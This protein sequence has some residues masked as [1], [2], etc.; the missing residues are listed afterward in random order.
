MDWEEARAGTA[1][2]KPIEGLNGPPSLRL[3]L[4]FG[5]VAHVRVRQR[6]RLSWAAMR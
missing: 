4:G 3:V 1:P 2:L 5:E 6:W